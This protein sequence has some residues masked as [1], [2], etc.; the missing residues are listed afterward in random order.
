[1]LNETLLLLQKKQHVGVARFPINDVAKARRVSDFGVPVTRFKRATCE[2]LT[3]FVKRVA[4]RI[5]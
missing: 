3:I 5:E 1:M 2:R 4:F